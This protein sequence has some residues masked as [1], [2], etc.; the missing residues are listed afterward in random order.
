M[1]IN[2]LFHLLKLSNLFL[3]SFH[4]IEDYISVALHNCQNPA[5]DLSQQESASIHL[6]T[7]Q[8]HSGPSLYLLLNQSLCAENREESKLWSSFLKLFL[9]TL[10]K[11]SPQSKTIWSG[12]RDEDL[13]SK[14]K[15]GTTFAW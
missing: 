2:H 3:D 14:Y 10:H 12:V 9:T 15:A 5:D 7:M 4:E 8:S 1:K 11:L 13:N 6:Y